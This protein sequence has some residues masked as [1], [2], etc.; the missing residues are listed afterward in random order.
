MS[1]VRADKGGDKRDEI[2]WFR[3]GWNQ[4]RPQAKNRI[5]SVCGDNPRIG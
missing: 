3:E 1:E 5:R 2:R 4:D